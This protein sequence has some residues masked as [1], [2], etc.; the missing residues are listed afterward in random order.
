[1][2]LFFVIADSAFL[3]TGLT[4]SS[5]FGLGNLLMPVFALFENSSGISLALGAGSI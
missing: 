2:I 4:L 1:M 3:S 5:G